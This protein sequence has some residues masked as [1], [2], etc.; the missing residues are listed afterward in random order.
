MQL[1]EPCGRRRERLDAEHAAIGVD[2]RGDVS[3]EMRVYPASDL[4]PRIAE[5]CT[6][7]I[8]EIAQS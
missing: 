7:S 8:T 1:N 4:V 3:V 6:E 2:R 5:A